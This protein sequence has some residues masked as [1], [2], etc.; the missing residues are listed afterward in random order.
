MNE[1]NTTCKLQ[2]TQKENREK[3]TKKLCHDYMPLGKID[4]APASALTP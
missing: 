3:V 4:V 1:A 2:D